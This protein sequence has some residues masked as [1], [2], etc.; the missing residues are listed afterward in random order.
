MTALAILLVVLLVLN[1]AAM[2]RTQEAAV[3][4]MRALAEIQVA[5]ERGCAEI[6]AGQALLNQTRDEIETMKNDLQR[7]AQA[8][9]ADFVVK[10]KAMQRFMALW[11]AGLKEEAREALSDV[12]FVEATLQ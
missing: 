10:L 3:A 12:G 9:T 5:I 2:L 1:G 8:N 7:E 4:N 6:D 11:N